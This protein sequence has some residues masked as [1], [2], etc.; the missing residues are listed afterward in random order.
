MIDSTVIRALHCAA[1]AK[2][3]HSNRVLG[4]SKVGF[5]PKFISAPTVQAFP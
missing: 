1:G 2:R 5:R 4:A 3:G